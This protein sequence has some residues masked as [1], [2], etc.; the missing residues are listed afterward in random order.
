M[1]FGRMPKTIS[2]RENISHQFCFVSFSLFFC[3]QFGRRLVVHA[4]K[5]RRK[6]K[7]LLF[8]VGSV[9]NFMIVKLHFTMSWICRCAHAKAEPNFAC[10][11]LNYVKRRIRFNY[12][13][14]YRRLNCLFESFPRQVFPDRRI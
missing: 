13:P 4:R 2:L 1:F 9:L 7:H 12:P 14:H 5:K 11:Q 8:H 6:T 10:C 3:F